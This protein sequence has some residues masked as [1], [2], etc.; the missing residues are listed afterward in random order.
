[1]SSHNHEQKFLC[2]RLAEIFLKNRISCSSMSPHKYN[3]HL[4]IVQYQ[5]NLSFKNS[6]ITMVAFRREYLIAA[7]LAAAAEGKLNGRRL[8]SVKVDDVELEEE[9]CVPVRK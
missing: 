8:P 2:T 6:I 5:Q 1:M 9:P 4:P 7:L 3:F